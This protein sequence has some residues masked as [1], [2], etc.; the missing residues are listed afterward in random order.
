MKSTK[1]ILK[2]NMAISILLFA[3]LVMGSLLVFSQSGAAINA[4][5]AA[6]DASAGLDIQFNNKG[7]LI[8]RM[9]TFDRNAISNPAVGLQIFNTT[10]MCFEYFAYGIWQTLSCATCP[11]PDDAG[12]ISGTS[13]IC[14]GQNVVSY[15]LPAIPNASSYIWLYSGTGATIN[16]TSNS[17]TIDYAANATS[18]IL[19]VKGNN[20]CGD[21]NNSPDYLIAVNSVP[22]APIADF[23]IP[24][25]TEIIWNWNVV[26]GA[27]GYKFNTTN[28]YASAVDNGT[29]TSYTQTGLTCNSSYTLYIWSYNSCGNS[30]STTLSQATTVCCGA[31][32]TVTFNYL[33]SSVTYGT[34][35]GQNSTC[36]LDRNL[37]ASQVANSF[38][39]ASA[40]GDLIQ[41]GRLDDGHQLRTSGTTTTLSPSDVP[42]HSNFIIAPTDWRSSPNNSLWQG[43]SGTNNPCPGGWRLP[44][45][46]EID[47]ERLSW[48]QDD[49]NGAFSSPLKWTTGGQRRPSGLITNTE[50]YGMYWCSSVST[51]PRGLSFSTSSSIGSYDK[52]AGRSVRCIRD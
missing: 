30:S 52:A 10:T 3:L 44:T 18:G 34:V 2:P 39:D 4:T 41:W 21:G 31:A 5:G 42:G 27:T 11:M 32:V 17:I 51:Y 8:P 47:N 23:H 35:L 28:N 6:P 25:A 24:S 38:D 40:Y 49:Y 19:T 45:E 1:N 9:T 15:S 22:T 7:L 12:T 33:G 29:N 43:V 36:W 37:G 13:A 14:Q 46:T 50:S 16:G 20:M 48:S 26:S